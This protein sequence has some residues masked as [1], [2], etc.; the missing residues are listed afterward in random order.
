M[1]NIK[2][3]IIEASYELFTTK[4]YEK[5][6]ISDI[7][8]VI[9]SS[10]GGFYH[11]FNSKE[12]ILEAITAG[13]LNEIEKSYYTVIN[14]HKGSSV[15]LF[16][17]IFETFHHY[18]EGQVKDWTKLQKLFSFEG[19]H[20]II[21]K[22]T[23]DFNELTAR[24][25]AEIIG[26]GTKKGEFTVKYTE[27]LAE[28]W[29]RE[30][31]QINRLARKELFKKEKN[32]SKTFIHQLEFTEEMINRELGLKDLSIKVKSTVLNYMHDIREIITLK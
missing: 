3:K 16:N 8:K 14:D 4:G 24:V 25:Y 5:T 28:L 18:K 30:M 20:A 29:A 15:E 2:D 22:I 23:R 1:M 19:N 13:Y 21:L 17:K 11:H 9:G 32:L 31:L 6:T 10:R 27:A 12:E 26:D 7:I